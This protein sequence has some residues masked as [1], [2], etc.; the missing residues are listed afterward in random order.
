MTD[1]R[2]ERI[3]RHSNAI[4]QDEGLAG[5]SHQEFVDQATAEMKLEDELAAGIIAN[6]TAGIVEA[7]APLWKKKP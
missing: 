6:A 3:T 1:N 4:R 5:R 7:A 2:H